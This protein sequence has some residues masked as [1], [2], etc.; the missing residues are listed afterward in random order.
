MLQHLLEHF[1]RNQHHH[2]QRSIETRPFSNIQR[3][4]LH[5][6]R[7]S[8]FLPASSYNFGSIHLRCLRF[9]SSFS[10][11]PSYLSHIFFHATSSSSIISFCRNRLLRF[12]LLFSLLIL[13]LLADFLHTLKLSAC[14]CSCSASYLWCF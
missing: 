11:L 14:S 9:Q 13:T 3:A 8:H 6:S 4:R 10:R 5:S 12:L 7:L 2:Q 1:R